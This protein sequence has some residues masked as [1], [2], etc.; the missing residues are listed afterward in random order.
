MIASNANFIILIMFPKSTTCMSAMDLTSSPINDELMV[1]ALSLL[2]FL[3][4]NILVN[5]TVQ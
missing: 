1:R 3:Y 5:I 4:I 2:V